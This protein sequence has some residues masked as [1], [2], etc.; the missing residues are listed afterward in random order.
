MREWKLKS[1][2]KR[3]RHS[4]AKWMGDDHDDPSD[5]AADPA[6]IFHL[7]VTTPLLIYVLALMRK[8]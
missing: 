3:V 8:A 6:F 4:V 2:W 5:E 7:I 1:A